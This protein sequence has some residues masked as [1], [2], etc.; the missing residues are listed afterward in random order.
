MADPFQYR[1]GSEY[2]G[3]KEAARIKQGLGE[4]LGTQMKRRV[5]VMQVARKISDK[6]DFFQLVDGAGQADGL[7]F[8][9][10]AFGEVPQDATEVGFFPQGPLA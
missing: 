4:N 8:G 7:G 3:P 9:F 2:L 10:F 1:V 6:N 5:A